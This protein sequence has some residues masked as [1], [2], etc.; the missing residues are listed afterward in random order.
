MDNRGIIFVEHDFRWVLV[1]S[2]N[3][4][5]SVNSNLGL[6]CGRGAFNTQS[7][8]SRIFMPFVAMQTLVAN[9]LVNGYD[10]C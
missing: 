3:L 2:V 7:F 5:Q 10:S 4:N 9:N 6:A 1:Q 8:Q